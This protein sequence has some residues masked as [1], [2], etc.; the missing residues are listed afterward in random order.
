MSKLIIFDADGTLVDRKSGDFLE[1]VEQWLAT[2]PQGVQLAIATNQGGPACRDTGW[3]MNRNYPTLEE[4][5]GRYNDLAQSI[6]ARLYMCLVY[7]DK[8]ETPYWP[9]D[10]WPSDWIFN[11]NRETDDPRTW[12]KWRKPEPGMLLR[13]MEDADASPDGTLMVGDRPEDEAAAQAAGV[14]FVWAHEFFGRPQ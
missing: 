9:K 6:G 7:V 2:R 12:L 11:Q 8:R 5:E 4:V 1:G 13:A 10:L 3:G 14:S